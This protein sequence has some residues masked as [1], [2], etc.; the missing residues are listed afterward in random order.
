MTTI[1]APLTLRTVQQAGVAAVAIT[2]ALDRH[3]DNH[4]ALLMDLASDPAAPM[5]AFAAAVMPGADVLDMPLGELIQAIKTEMPP[6]LE[7][8]SRYIEVEVTPQLE[9]LA[10]MMSVLAASALQP[11][12][13]SDG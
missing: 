4:S 6:V 3:G 1:K 5:Q 9:D 7:A 2:R 10:T 12:A 13:D 8:H 11:A